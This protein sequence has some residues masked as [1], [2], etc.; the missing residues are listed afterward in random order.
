[1][2]SR[3]PQLFGFFS[4]QW[5]LLSH[6]TSWFFILL[7]LPDL[8]MLEAW[9]LSPESCCLLVQLLFGDL[10]SHGFKCQ[11]CADPES[12]TSRQNVLLS[13]RPVSCLW[14][15]SLS[16]PHWHLQPGC[17]RELSTLPVY[18][19]SPLGTPVSRNNFLLTEM[20]REFRVTCSTCHSLL[21]IVTAI[22]P[23]ILMPLWPLTLWVIILP[24][25]TV[26][27]LPVHTASPTSSTVQRLEWAQWLHHKSSHAERARTSQ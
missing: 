8:H 24:V 21:P 14:D 19:A 17:L 12:Y 22:L 2:I 23:I 20:F 7:S 25:P 27:H 9:S 16:A 4:A 11:L 5:P 10:K 6:L 26:A 3:T 13:S 15:I 18:Y 1:M